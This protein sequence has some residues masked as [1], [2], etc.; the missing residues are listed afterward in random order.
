VKLDGK[1][2][3]TVARKLNID[4]GNIIFDNFVISVRDPRYLPLM[5]GMAVMVARQAQRDK[6][7]TAVTLADD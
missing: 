5:A 7:E 1:Q 3:G 4:L 6:V 2:I